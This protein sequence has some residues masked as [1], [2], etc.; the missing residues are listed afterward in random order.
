M[1]RTGAYLMR[2]YG[3]DEFDASEAAYLWL[4]HHHYGQ[5]SDEYRELCGLMRTFRPSPMRTLSNASPDVQDLY[6]ALCERADCPS[7]EDA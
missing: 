3:A 2:E 7:H 1:T 5:A 4:S 6:D